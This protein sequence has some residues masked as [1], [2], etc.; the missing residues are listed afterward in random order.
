MRKVGDYESSV[1]G[2][3]ALDAYALAPCTVG[4]EVGPS[5]NAHVDLVVLRL[6]QPELLCF[7]FVDIVDITIW[8][9]Y[10]SIVKAHKAI[11]RTGRVCDLL[12]C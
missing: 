12:I 7:P 1:V 6:Q 2:R 3:L 4:V 8:W 11:G 10:V 9:S 5:I